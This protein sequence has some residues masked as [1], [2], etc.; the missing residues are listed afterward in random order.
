MD[1]LLNQLLPHMISSDVHEGVQIKLP[2]PYQ[3][4][5]YA[6][7]SRGNEGQST[8]VVIRRDV[9]SLLT[10]ELHC[11]II[12]LSMTLHPVNHPICMYNINSE[13]YI[14]TANGINL[15]YIRIYL[16]CAL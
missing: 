10:R 7:R 8:T 11:N 14:F 16:V 12:L 6:C 3:S 15:M 13:L 4:L 2:P 5:Q 1:K 9:K